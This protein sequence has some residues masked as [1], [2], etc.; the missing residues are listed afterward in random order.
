[1][2]RIQGA[3]GLILVIES[4]RYR[5]NT[6]MEEMKGVNARLLTLEISVDV[7]RKYQHGVTPLLT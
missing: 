1:M 3:A 7:G 4:R 6:I 2:N 5:G